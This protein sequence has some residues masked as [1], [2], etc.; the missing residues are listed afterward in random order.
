[1]NSIVLIDLL[2]CKSWRRHLGLTAVELMV[3]ISLLA[4]IASI[5]VPNFNGL[6]QRWRV[7]Q[8][9]EAMHSAIH[10]ARSEA[11]KRSGQVALQRISTS[12][13][14]QA[15]ARTNDWSCGWQVCV[16]GLGQQLCAPDALVIQRFEAPPGLQVQRS[17]LGEGIRFDRWGMPVG[18]F[19]FSLLPKGKGLED[20]AAKGL[21]TSRGGRVRIADKP[22]CPA[23]G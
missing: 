3:V 7:R 8:S 11:I 22:P 1:M 16:H 6:L 15:R 18:G 13:H 20:A 5:A 17:S 2:N 10:L 12:G 4:I 23:R 19:S 9:L 21:C 14:C